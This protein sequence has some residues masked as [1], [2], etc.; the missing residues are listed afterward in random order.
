MAHTTPYDLKERI[1]AEI[2]RLDE[3]GIILKI[4]YSE[5]QCHLL[6]RIIQFVCSVYKSIINNSLK[7]DHYP[8]LHIGDIFCYYNGR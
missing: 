8:I 6:R 7:D 3:L 2:D 5:L 1:D 4:D